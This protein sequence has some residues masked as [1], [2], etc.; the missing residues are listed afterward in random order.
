MNKKQKISE[1]LYAH[2]V[3]ILDGETITHH[4]C[5]TGDF[6]TVMKKLNNWH[7]NKETLACYNDFFIITD[8]CYLINPSL[9]EY[10]DN[11]FSNIGI[12][13]ITLN[14]AG[15]CTHYQEHKLYLPN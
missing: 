1:S 11:Y 5:V 15:F 8:Q 2:L 6:E 14:I 12:N 3:A 9:I 10:D 13:S 7:S 4:V